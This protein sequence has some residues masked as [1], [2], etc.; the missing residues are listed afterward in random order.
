MGALA[1]LRQGHKPSRA[2]P[3]VPPTAIEHEPIDPGSSAGATNLEIEAVSIRIHA[4]FGDIVHDSSGQ[5]LD[6]PCHALL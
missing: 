1:G 2:K 4:A 3:H 5:P 6:L